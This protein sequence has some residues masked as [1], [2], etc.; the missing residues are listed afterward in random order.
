MIYVAWSLYVG[1]ILISSFLI[2][3]LFENQILK[4]FLFAL[5]LSLFL[6]VWFSYPGETNLSPA[7]SIF[8]MDL[9]ETSNLKIMRIIRPIMLGFIVIFVLDLIFYIKKSRI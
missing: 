4:R 7:I 8:F 3:R 5:F 6:S 1:I 9:F 2:R